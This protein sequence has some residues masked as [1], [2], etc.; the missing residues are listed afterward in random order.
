MK[1][2]IKLTMTMIVAVCLCASSM[3]FAADGTWNVDANG[4]WSAN[5]NWVSDT[6]ANGAGSKAYFNNNFSG[7]WVGAPRGIVVDSPRTIGEFYFGSSGSVWNYWALQLGSITLDN[8]GSIPIVNVNGIWL[9]G[10]DYTATLLGSSGFNKTGA[11]IFR[12]YG[13]DNISGPVIISE[14]TLGAYNTNALKSA[15]VI[16]NGGSLE[17]GSDINASFKSLIA[18]SGDGNLGLIRPENGFIASLNTP[19]TASYPDAGNT[20]VVNVY[21]NSEINLNSN[22]TM[23]ANT[24]FAVSGNGSI[25]NIN[26]PISGD[27]DLRLLGRSVAHVGTYNINAPCIYTGITKFEAWGANPRFELNVNQA[28]PVGSVD[29]ALQLYVADQ[30]AWSDTPNTGIILDLNN[31]TQKFS[32]VAF[33]I[34]AYPSNNYVE[35]TGGDAGVFEITN[36][37]WSTAL[38]SNSFIKL[39]GGKIINNALSYE[40]AMPMII[41]N[42]TLIQNGSWN[43][44]TDAKFELQAGGKIGGSGVIGVTGGASSD[45]VIPSGSTIT[46]GESIGQV[47]CWNLELEEGSF[48]DWEVDI[49]SFDSIDVNGSLTLPSVINSVTVNVSKLGSVQFE[50]TNWMFYVGQHINGTVASLYLDYPHNLTGPENPVMLNGNVMITGLIP[51]PATFGLLAILGLA[52]LRRK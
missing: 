18:T 49:D 50:Q 39:S 52:F 28:I 42:A 30:G 45:L 48:Y 11:D 1:N 16:V 32:D 29:K 4:D 43:G 9:A 44:S 23:T 19:L 6:P 36:Y 22:I 17:I 26:A 15:D 3:L 31:T 7:D 14:G 24:A 47:G 13:N 38:D 51:E 10:T 37:F 34:A 35:I 21:D 41:T 46:P 27:Y 8:N 2:Q 25:I 5:S 20:F 33:S 40:L 12:L